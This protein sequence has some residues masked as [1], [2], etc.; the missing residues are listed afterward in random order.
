MEF[1]QQQCEYLFALTDDVEYLQQRLKSEVEHFCKVNF[2][3]VPEGLTNLIRHILENSLLTLPQVETSP[4]D[5][6][7]ETCPPQEPVKTILE[8]QE[9]IPDVQ[10]I[11]WVDKQ[12]AEI[13]QEIDALPVV[14]PAP[15]G[16]QSTMELDAADRR[17]AI[18]EFIKDTGR[19][20]TRRQIE[21]GAG[22]MYEGQR[23]PP[24]EHE[25]VKQKVLKDL[26]VLKQEKRIR[27][28]I[29][30]KDKP[31]KGESDKIYLYELWTDDVPDVP[32]ECQLAPSTSAITPDIQQ[33]L[34][35]AGK[36]QSKNDLLDIL[37]KIMVRV[38]GLI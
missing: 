7:I 12:L 17:N 31:G 37:L 11:S 18:Y 28:V 19:S 26:R 5:E 16:W 8:A 38:R 32:G 25:K 33:M 20:Q 6:T 2:I 27:E 4:L 22:Y 30:K 35:D 29:K 23:L 34:L 13:A 10:Q 14:E 3:P 21:V 24:E 1:L 15:E 36:A 9:D